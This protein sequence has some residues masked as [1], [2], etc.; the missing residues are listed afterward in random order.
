MFKKSVLVAICALLMLGGVANAKDKPP[1]DKPPKP[2]K[3]Y[4]AHKSTEVRHQN[5]GLVGAAGVAVL[6]Q[7]TGVS[8]GWAARV[9]VRTNWFSD[10]IDLGS[11][12]TDDAGDLRFT[13]DV[14]DAPPVPGVH[15]LRLEGTGA[16]GQFRRV[17]LAIKVN[18][19]GGVASALAAG[20]ANSTLGRA[21]GSSFAKTG[22]FVANSAYVGFALLMVGIAL[23]V[24]VRKR[25]VL[26]RG[27]AS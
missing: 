1:K 16:N 10:P 2:P 24:G 17:D 19:A 27:A 22:A 14:P 25:K 3:N 4:P 6:E 13:F 7:L 11:Y 18:A 15:T 8:T 23:F 21:S 5:G 26:T 9:P 20:S 12:L